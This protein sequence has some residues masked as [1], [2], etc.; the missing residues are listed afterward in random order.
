MMLAPHCKILW[1]L[2]MV[3]M[4]QN[5]G[6]VLEMVTEHYLLRGEE[7]T[8]GRA[9]ALSIYSQAIDAL[10]LGDIQELGRLTTH[11]FHGPLQKI[12]PW[13]TNH[14]TEEMIRRCGHQYKDSFWGFWMLGGMAGG[15]RDGVSV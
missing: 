4:A 14:F 11:N 2:C 15:R 9:E 8:K 1:S 10:Q 13:A 12:I 5:V 3:G 6:P 7:A